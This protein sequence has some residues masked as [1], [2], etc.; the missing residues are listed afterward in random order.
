M[1]RQK[2][3]KR[4]DKKRKSTAGNHWT[5]RTEH[6]MRPGLCRYEKYCRT[7]S[8]D[9]GCPAGGAQQ[10]DIACAIDDGERAA[11]LEQGER[12]RQKERKNT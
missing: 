7:R 12:N 6:S 2:R 11:Y 1:G 3:K 9:G 8:R 5:N 10:C 4:L